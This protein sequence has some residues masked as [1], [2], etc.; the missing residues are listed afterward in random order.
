MLVDL[1][2]RQIAL[3]EQTLRSQA[4]FSQERRRQ[5]LRLPPFDGKNPLEVFTWTQTVETA[6]QSIGSLDWLGSDRAVAKISSALK[7]PASAWFNVSSSKFLSMTWWQFKQELYKKYGLLEKDNIAAASLL[8]L[9]KVE[10]SNYDVFVGQYNMLL[11]M[12]TNDD[13]LLT[14]FETT[15]LFQAFKAGMPQCLTQVACLYK[16]RSVV[17]LQEH[18]VWHMSRDHELARRA[19]YSTGTNGVIPTPMELGLTGARGSANTAAVHNAQVVDSDDDLPVDPLEL[20]GYI[21]DGQVYRD[22]AGVVYSNEDALYTV[23][24]FF[25]RGSSRF[26]RGNRYRSFRGRGS[27][28]GGQIQL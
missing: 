28:G 1:H 21:W 13:S 16:G 27:F 9:C 8:Q 12:V 10:N 15:L 25:R 3:S 2:A 7:P 6:F 5:D 20:Q 22:A 24:A 17:E 23:G 26:N 14:E 4:H 18:L 19:G 11:T